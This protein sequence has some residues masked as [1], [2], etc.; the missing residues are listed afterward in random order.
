ML[1]VE[2]QCYCKTT[3]SH[4]VSGVCVQ[5]GEKVMGEGAGCTAMDQVY[6]ITC[7]T[8]QHCQIPLQGKPFYGLE[9]KPYCENDYLVGVMI[10]NFSKIKTMRVKFP[11]LNYR[12][13]V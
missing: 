8:C 12:Y 4:V 7:F 2:Y 11:Q 9:G 1:F 13:I 5:C 6:H 3:F 10:A